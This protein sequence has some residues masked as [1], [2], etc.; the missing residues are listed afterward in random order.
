[1][2]RPL[3]ESDMPRAITGRGLILTLCG[4]VFVNGRAEINPTSSA[5][6]RLLTVLNGYPD[7]N[8]TIEGHTDTLGSDGYNYDL[9]QRRADC[10]KLYL[11]AH[12]IVTLRIAT[13]GMGGS[14]P[15][16]GNHT[17]AGRRQNSRVEVIV[18]TA[19]A[20]S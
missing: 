6:E 17:A 1:M 2:E 13:Q 5:L 19:R 14:R 4:S 20:A 3:Q 11:M 15:V 16:A 18:H 12:G 9:S 7:S 8:I 10:V